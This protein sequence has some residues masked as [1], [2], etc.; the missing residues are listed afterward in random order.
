M[1]LLYMS[2]SRKAAAEASP[3]TTPA[4]DSWIASTLETELSLK[5]LGLRAPSEDER[6]PL[7]KTLNGSEPDADVVAKIESQVHGV[8]VEYVRF[9][10]E[11][12]AQLTLRIRY[13]DSSSSNV[14]KRI[15][16]ADVP[17]GVRADFERRSATHVFRTWPF[18]WQRIRVA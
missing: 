11:T 4:I 16:L 15:P 10:H 7:A 12:D 13:E 6:K 5:V 1:T 14:S 18:P 2:R 8:E 9:A 3:D 17:E